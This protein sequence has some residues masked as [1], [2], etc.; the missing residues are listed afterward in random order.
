MLVFYSGFLNSTM[1]VMHYLLRFASSTTLGIAAFFAVFLIPTNTH[2]AACWNT[3]WD[4]FYTTPQQTVS[5]ISP[6]PG[7]GCLPAG[8]GPYGNFSQSW[9]LIDAVPASPFTPGVTSTLNFA[10][11]GIGYYTPQQLAAYTAPS[12]W[13]KT[14]AY[15]YY[16]LDADG[17]KRSTTEGV[18]QAPTV[19]ASYAGG[20]TYRY[21]LL[22]FPATISVNLP[23]PGT[24]YIRSDYATPDGSG[25]FGFSTYNY[26]ALPFSVALPNSAP[27]TPTITGPTTGVTNTNYQFSISA[28][29]ANGDQV[30]YSIDWDNNGS[31]DGTTL[32]R[33]S[34]WA[35]LPSRSWSSVGTYTFRARA[36]D[37]YSSTSGW[38]SHTITISNPTPQCADGIDND[39]DGLVD[40][41]DPG[42][43][44]GT[45]TTESPNPQCSDGINNDTD[46]WTDYPNDPGCISAADTTESPN[47]QCSDG[48]D[49]NG[50]GEI[51]YPADLTCSSIF[52]NNE[53]VAAAASLSLTAPSLVQPNSTALLSWSAANVQT[54][55]CTLTGTNGNSWNLTGT[56]GTRT[57]TALTGETTFTLSCTDLNS[58]VETV[59]TTVRITPSF[60]EI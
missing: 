46:A 6:P 47:P 5:G 4:F 58:D 9:G 19:L 22:R 42:C 11:T 50:N 49:N 56:S 12:A 13:P 26:L 21:Y 48:I 8:A 51:D 30:R 38:R 1:S 23:A 35:W 57:S 55:S 29:D 24:Y 16:V 43:T 37:T 34:G 7:S 54:N 15:K 18:L 32:Y 27:N 14:Y 31:I 17:N 25:D 41:A 52:D 33:E 60:E 2:A 53:E 59:A 10:W 39:G 28:T 44:G 45:D 40:L 20:G 36:E 3:G